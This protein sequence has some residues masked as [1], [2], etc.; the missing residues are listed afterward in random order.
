M[1]GLDIYV[2]DLLPAAVHGKRA[3]VRY[4]IIILQDNVVAFGF[5]SIKMLSFRHVE[6]IICIPFRIKID[7]CGILRILTPFVVASGRVRIV[8]VIMQCYYGRSAVY[9]SSD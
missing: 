9:K 2:C 5:Q 6:K 7:F 1:L 8:P 3:V 4:C